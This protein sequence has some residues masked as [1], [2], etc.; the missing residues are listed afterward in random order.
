MY[1]IQLFSTLTK[2]VCSWEAQLEGNALIRCQAYAGVSISLQKVIP[3]VF[4]NTTTCLRTFSTD[5]LAHKPVAVNIN[6]HMIAIT[7]P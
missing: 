7:F 1:R 4:P 5:E 2:S 3:H 6:V